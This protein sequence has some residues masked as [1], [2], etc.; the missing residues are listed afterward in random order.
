[1]KCKHCNNLLPNARGYAKI[2]SR[3]K[4]I[5]GRIACC[6]PGCISFGLK[7]GSKDFQEY[8]MGHS[9]EEIEQRWKS[10]IDKSTATNISR[11]N[12]TGDKNPASKNRF[13]DKGLSEVEIQQHLSAKAKKGVT[14]KRNQGFYDVKS[15]NPYSI[16]FWIK[17]GFDKKQASQKIN[18]R[19]HNKPEFWINKGYSANEAAI[20]ATKSAATN[21]LSEKIKRWGDADGE[22]KYIEVRKKLSENWSPR[23]ASGKNFASSKQ[24]NLFFK[25]LYKFCRRLG[26]ERNDLV[27]KLNRGEWFL[28]DEAAIYFYDFLL[29]PLRIIVEFNGEHVHP[30]KNKL[31][32][33]QWNSWKHAF[34]KKP[35]DEVYKYDQDKVLLAKKAGYNVIQVWSKDPTSFENVANF[36]KGLHHGNQNHKA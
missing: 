34:S 7:P 29:K 15:N 5:S 3:G 36:I 12:F 33:A 13:K 17:R 16:E 21:S 25:K 30:N 1:M 11:G 14:T 24:A 32:E 19:I 31:T 4:F 8:V 35:A 9:R 6:L 20:I 23:A 27:F 28:R 26:Y 22:L 18:S 10:R 2:N